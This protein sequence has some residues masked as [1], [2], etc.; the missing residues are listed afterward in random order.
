M[1]IREA[2]PDEYDE[3]GRVTMRAYVEFFDAG[4]IDEGTSYLRRIGDVAARAP[5]TT[6]LV[7]I[8]D[9]AIVGSLTLEL[10]ERTPGGSEGKPPLAPGEAHIRMLGVDPAARSRGA[11]RQL[12]REAETRAR[13]AGKTEITLH[14][15]HE[16]GTA[17]S[18]YHTLG[19]ERMADEVMPDGFVLLGYRKRLGPQ[20]A[21]SGT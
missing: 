13:A 8:D 6:I 17:R 3:T 19:Y 5:H 10:D 1:L 16:M 15:T 9:G 2:T 21:G 11:G 12:M 4:A 14:T 18:M 20:D 7:A